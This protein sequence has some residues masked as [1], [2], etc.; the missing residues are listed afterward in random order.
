MKLL[1]SILSL[2]SVVV[3]Y[4]AVVDRREL[5]TELLIWSDSLFSTWVYICTNVVRSNVL[6]STCFSFLFR[7]RRCPELHIKW[8]YV[9]GVRGNTVCIW[10]VTLRTTVELSSCKYP[11]GSDNIELNKYILNLIFLRLYIC[12]TLWRHRD[13]I[14]PQVTDTFYEKYLHWWQL[15]SHRALIERFQLDPFTERYYAIATHS[16]GFEPATIQNG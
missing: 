2:D 9:L 7:R 13:R 6:R 3:I 12:L 8:R 16:K 11:F 10:S 5:S 4:E 14:V 1:C 15:C